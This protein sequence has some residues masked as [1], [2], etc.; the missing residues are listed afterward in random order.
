[1]DPFIKPTCHQAWVGQRPVATGN[2]FLPPRG[3]KAKVKYH[4]C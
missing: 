1:M 2:S 4:V 3:T